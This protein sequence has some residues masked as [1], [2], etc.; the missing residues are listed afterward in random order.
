MVRIAKYAAALG[1]RC[2]Y[3]DQGLYFNGVDGFGAFYKAVKAQEPSVGICGDIGNTLFVN[4]DPVAFFR[5]FASEFCHVHLKDYVPCNADDEG[6]NVTQDGSYVKE[7][8]IGEGIIDTL[9]CLDALKSCGYT[10][11]IALENNHA[12]DFEQGVR[13]AMELVTKHMN[14]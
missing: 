1:I 12:E 11:A 3:E 5:E 10:G 8:V 2:L 13:T 7:S 14:L 4:E 6:A 9:S